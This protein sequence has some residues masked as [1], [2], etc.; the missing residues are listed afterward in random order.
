MASLEHKRRRKLFP[1]ISWRNRV[2]PEPLLNQSLP[3]QV[4]G[5]ILEQGKI[6]ESSPTTA[7]KGEKN[8]WVKQQKCLQNDFGVV[9]LTS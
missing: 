3:V 9:L 5:E 7:P 4:K 1:W 2:T 6:A 8:G